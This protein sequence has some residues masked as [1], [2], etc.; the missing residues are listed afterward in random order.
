MPG[1]RLALT[2]NIRALDNA[3]KKIAA[4]TTEVAKL[5]AITRKASEVTSKRQGGKS[6]ETRDLEQDQARRHKALTKYETI[7]KRDALA[8][9][10]TRRRLLVNE[11]QVA[12][13]TERSRKLAN[14]HAARQTLAQWGFQRQTEQSEQR[15]AATKE[16]NARQ[17]RSRDISERRLFR[18]RMMDTSM[19]I[20]QVAYSTGIAAALIGG[21]FIKTALAGVQLNDTLQTTQMVVERILRSTEDTSL[22]TNLKQAAQDFTKQIQNLSV[23]SPI[24]TKEMISI[25][26]RYVTASSGMAKASQ[27][28]KE[29]SILGDTA[30]AISNAYGDTEEYTT[31]FEALTRAIARMRAWGNVNTRIF[32]MLATQGVPAYRYMAEYYKISRQQVVKLLTR[33]GGVPVG[34]VEKAI[35][36]G[37]TKDF[38]GIQMEALQ[39][40]ATAALEA[41]KDKARVIFGELSQYTQAWSAKFFINVLKIQSAFDSLPETLRKAFA[42]GWTGITIM[43]IAAAA[44]LATFTALAVVMSGIAITMAGLPEALQVYRHGIGFKGPIGTIL[45]G[46]PGIRGKA[47]AVF[48]IG[49]AAVGAV[50]ESKSEK[51]LGEL[52]T[53]RFRA[54]AALAE[55]NAAMLSAGFKEAFK[56]AEML[57]ELKK[58][59][60]MGF[61]GRN[62]YKAVDDFKVVGRTL[63][64]GFKGYAAGYAGLIRWPLTIMA[65]V[66]R[67]IP[68]GKGALETV[69]ETR[70]FGWLALIS[71]VSKLAAKVSPETRLAISG[72]MTKTFPRGARWFGEVAA[73]TLGKL[74]SKWLPVIGWVLALR[75]IVG[76]LNKVYDAATL[77]PEK[78]IPAIM[79]AAKSLCDVFRGLGRT[80]LTGIKWIWMP[81][82]GF[83]ARMLAGIPGGIGEGAR[84]ELRR[85]REEEAIRER[86]RQQREKQPGGF[87]T[88]WTPTRSFLPPGG[89]RYMGPPQHRQA[90]GSVS[91]GTSYM[92][93][94]RGPELLVPS[95]PGYIHPTAAL[96]Q[97]RKIPTAALVRVRE[98]SNAL[99][100]VLDLILTLFRSRL[101]SLLSVIASLAIAQKRMP[102]V[103]PIPPKRVEIPPIPLRGGPELWG[104][105]MTRGYAGTVVRGPRGTAEVTSEMK[106]GD[107]VVVIKG[108]SREAKKVVMDIHGKTQW[109]TGLS[110]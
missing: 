42:L 18:F 20:R 28:G 100:F 55:P 3:S 94:E 5:G 12:D 58:I 43:G 80:L 37:M 108:V 107:L 9:A 52:L 19:L 65:K 25:A 73:T 110:Y 23:I 24:K 32:R 1:N 85:L 69:G 33:K 60:K 98:I 48:A 61:W 93:G 103:K 91:K 15:L 30:M 38:G 62:F 109:S 16:R 44:L 41:V 70:I 82:Y 66:V 50:G 53:S 97:I 46:A 54:M 29:F 6:A 87:P 64:T 8:N 76:V 75:D 96:V 4:I 13:K 35:F 71:G 57:A 11:A 49:R 2:I 79:S 40:N 81:F 92:V 68:G 86:A 89:G 99:V 102:I 88:G 10:Q 21:F 67:L 104:T 90:G 59:S 105:E 45:R 78:I 47:K 74:V 56:S 83:L 106:G 84:N 51:Q 17:Q 22:G 14:E 26:N 77:T 63:R 101:M 27:L 7:R 39:R 72:W 31:R 36:A 95:S 34:I